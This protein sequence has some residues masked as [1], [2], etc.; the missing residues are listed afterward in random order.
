VAAPL[1]ERNFRILF[2]GRVVDAFG[3]AVSPAALT[4][5]V[6]T[7][8]RSS[9]GLAV[10]LVCGMLPRVALLPFGGVVVDRAGARRVALA[11]DVV[12][13][14][15]QLAIGILLLGDHLVIAPVAVAAAVGGAAAAFGVPATLPLVAGTVDADGRLAAN[16]LLGVAN[17]A[18]SVAGPAIAGVLIFTVGAGWAFVLDAAT[19]AVSAGTL[20]VIRVRP[21]EVPRQPLRRQLVAGWVEV[22]AR[23]WYWSSIIGHGTCNFA[24]GM[25]MTTGPLIAVTELGGKGVWLAAL[26]ASAAGYLVGALIAGRARV[27]R[28]VLAVDLVLM[29]FAV[30]LVLFALPAPAWA[31]VTAYGLAAIGLGF[32][33]PVWL[34]AVQ[35]EVPAAALARVSAY[36]WLVSLGAQLLGYAAAPVLAHAAGFAWPLSGA[37]ILVVITLLVPASLPSVR[38]L[39]FYRPPADPPVAGT[40]APAT[41]TEND[42]AQSEAR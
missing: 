22:R 8:T 42:S 27:S 6:V 4:L 7:E 26:E 15:A 37:A 33:S 18:T 28:G 35:Q 10:I 24:L 12:S 2:A 40:V 17:S 34:T 36:D 21:M 19:F 16:S 1:R 14:L 13:G 32:A 30:P 5:A 11:S 41:G 25:L 31:D 20:A 23:T 9:V 29:S 39:R 38:E 3:D